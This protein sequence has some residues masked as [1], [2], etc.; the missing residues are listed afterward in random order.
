MAK[1]FIDLL[2]NEENVQFLRNDFDEYDLGDLKATK[3]IN[4]QN[5][6]ITIKGDFFIDFYKNAL[7][8]EDSDFVYL[9]IEMKRIKRFV[10]KEGF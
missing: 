4:E 5:L 9:R 8:I 6:E 10:M 2:P 1:L 3:Y 7:W